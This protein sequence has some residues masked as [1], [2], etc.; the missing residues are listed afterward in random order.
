MVT[1]DTRLA[2][3]V[4]VAAVAALRLLELRVANRNTRAALARGAV[5]AGRR[6]YPWMVAMHSA[7]LGACLLET[8]VL[9]RP[10]VPSL[11]VAAA[12]VLV[13]A[14]A[15]R[16]WV[17]ATLGRRWTTRVVYVPGDP[18]VTHGPFRWLH[19]P[20]YVVVAAEVAALPLV[21]GAWLTAV[22]FTVANALLLR[23]RIAIEN[24]LL[25]R[26]ASGAR[27]PK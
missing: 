15:G 20:N 1:V 19:H 10:W 26:L 5:E 3:T 22:T 17:V 18:L 25:N 21:H 14:A 27:T 11:A 8:W 24:A 2:Y 12:A 23:K 4:L 7:F 16:Y 6:H 9:D 13:A